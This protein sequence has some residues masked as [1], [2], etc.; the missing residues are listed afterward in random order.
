M[1]RLDFSIDSWKPYQILDFKITFCLNWHAPF[2]IKTLSSRTGENRRNIHANTSHYSMC[3]DSWKMTCLWPLHCLPWIPSSFTCCALQSD[4][5]WPYLWAEVKANLGM[6]PLSILHN[7]QQLT[8]L[9]F[10]MLD[11]ALR[12]WFLFLWFFFASRIS[13]EPSLGF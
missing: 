3:T 13:V 4:S 5:S 8:D 10:C 11:N 9:I 12:N 1:I 2:N 6:H 7:K